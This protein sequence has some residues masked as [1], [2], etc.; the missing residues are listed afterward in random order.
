MGI[1]FST[2]NYLPM[3]TT[4]NATS[5]PNTDIQVHF[6]FSCIFFSFFKDVQYPKY[7]ESAVEFDTSAQYISS[8]KTMQLSNYLVKYLEK[9]NYLQ[10]TYHSSFHLVLLLIACESNKQAPGMDR[11]EF[12]CYLHQWKLDHKMGKTVEVLYRT[13]HLMRC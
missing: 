3:K 5:P 6:D 4:K 12:L 2:L 1:G 10:M 13:V 11:E 9:K 7:S 8:S